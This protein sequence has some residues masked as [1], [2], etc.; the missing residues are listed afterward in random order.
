MRLDGEEARSRFAAARV[1]RL[2]TVSA[3]G[4]PHLVPVTFAVSGDGIVFAIDHKPKSTH[5]LR[6]LANIAANPAVSF[7]ADIYDEDW[8][9]LWWVRADGVASIEEPG[10]VDALVA[11]YAQYAERPPEG[12]VVRTRVT[13]W[14]GWA[15]VA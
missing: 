13:R 5:A 12:P 9:R 4:Q 8:T 15:G 7:L 10:P 6:R 11:K 3:D 2:A 1:A 14:S